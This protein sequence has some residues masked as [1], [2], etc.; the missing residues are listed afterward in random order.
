MNEEDKRICLKAV[1]NHNKYRVEENLSERELYF[2]NLVRDSDKIDL[3]DTQKN[4]ISDGKADINSQIMDA[5]LHHR[6]Y[7]KKPFDE[8]NQSSAI[9]RQ[10]CFLFD[11]NFKKSFQIII[12][13]GI[14]ERKINLLRENFSEDLVDKIE[15]NIDDYIKSRM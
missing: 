6:L 7:Q 11:L 5:L 10:L 14:I 2:V 13:K 9:V 15:K 4:E 3:L 12:N 1:K 8:E